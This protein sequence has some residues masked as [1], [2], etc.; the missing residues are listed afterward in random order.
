MTI[1]I[2]RLVSGDASVFRAMLTMFGQVFGDEP[3]YIAKQPSDAYLEQLLA[4]SAMI[5]IAAVDAGST[6]GG[7]VAYVLP[8]FEQERSEVYIYDLAVLQSHR[9]RGL[10]TR[11]IGLLQDEV[12]ARG[13]YVIFVQADRGDDAAIQL[14]SKLGVREDVLHFDI[15]VRRS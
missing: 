6:V 4:G 7:L 8:K 9:R 13:A 15:P 10:A 5:A 14:Y 3:S 1:R 2:R 11:M 12:R